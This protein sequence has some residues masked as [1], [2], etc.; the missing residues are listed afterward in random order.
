MSL[1]VTIT[2]G[3][4]RFRET[5]TQQAARKRQATG[6]FVACFIIIA[7]LAANIAINVIFYQ[8]QDTDVNMQRAPKFNVAYTCSKYALL[9]SDEL[10]LDF[11]LV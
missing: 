3:T 2:P 6:L 8:Q 1:F 10:K 9:C 7:L 5:D 4:W 11:P